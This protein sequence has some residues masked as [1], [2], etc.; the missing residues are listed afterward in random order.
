MSGKT[1]DIEMVWAEDTHGKAIKSNGCEDAL[2][3]LIVYNT[4]IAEVSHAI[5]PVPICSSLSLSPNLVNTI[6][7]SGQAFDPVVATPTGIMISH[8]CL[9][10]E[11]VD[12][13]ELKRQC[14]GTPDVVSCR[15]EA[16]AYISGIIKDFQGGQPYTLKM[17]SGTTVSY[18]TGAK[19]DKPWPTNMPRPVQIGPMDF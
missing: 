17:F 15:S 10:D 9:G 2:A 1:P 8:P 12:A 14:W 11:F 16:A 5:L 19:F 3:V 13:D 18:P 6:C 4:R 7:S